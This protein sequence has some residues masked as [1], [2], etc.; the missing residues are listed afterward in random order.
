[1]GERLNVY[2]GEIGCNAFDRIALVRVGPKAGSCDHA[3][4]YVVFRGSN[5]FFY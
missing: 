2:F 5:R 4:E 3:V 1:M